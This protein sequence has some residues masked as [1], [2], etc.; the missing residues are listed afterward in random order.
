MLDAP[1]HCII[2]GFDVP[3][4]PAHLKC[5]T[6]I[7][8]VETETL[9]SWDT[10]LHLNHSWIVFD[11]LETMSEFFLQ[12]FSFLF[13]FTSSCLFCPLLSFFISSHFVWSHV[14]S[15]RFVSF[16][17]SSHLILSHLASSSFC[18]FFHFVSFRLVLSS[19]SVFLLSYLVLSQLVSPRLVLFLFSSFILSSLSQLV[20]FSLISSCFVSSL[21]FSS[22]LIPLHLIL[23]RLMSH[24]LFLSHVF[25]FVSSCLVLFGL[26]SPVLLSLHL[27]SC[28][29]VSYHFCLFFYFISSCCIWSRL[30]SSVFFSQN[31]FSHLIVSFRVTIPCLVVVNSHLIFCHQIEICFFCLCSFLIWSH[32]NLF[33]LISCCLVFFVHFN[34]SNCILLRFVSPPHRSFI[35]SQLISSNLFYILSVFISHCF[36]FC[37]VSHFFS[38]LI[39][40]VLLKFTHSSFYEIYI[41]IDLM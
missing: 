40:F 23:S 41:Y 37:L 34:S 38:F 17:F 31:H 29:I 27:V 15:S 6:W 35:L 19:S 18:P 2:S 3:G 10:G 16:L 13:P 11:V 24:W 25:D 20:S 28:H 8:R 1:L 36:L 9:E 21:Q 33:C 14:I 32:P 12:G 7:W 26:F 39:Y 30:F 4:V 5:S 22:R